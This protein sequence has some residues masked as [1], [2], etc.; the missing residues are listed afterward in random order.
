MTKGG[1]SDRR[2]AAFKASS[3]GDYY[4]LR[5][6]SEEEEESNFVKDLQ[7]G[8]GRFRGKLPFK[9]FASGRVGHYAAKCPHKDKGKEPVRWN[10]KQNAKKS[11]DL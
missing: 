6:A 5:H 3:K 4:E 1:P 10:K 8:T 7:R 11:F 2:E 9:C